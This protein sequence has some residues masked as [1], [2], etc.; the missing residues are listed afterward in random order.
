MVG[1]CDCSQELSLAGNG[2]DVEM[3]DTHTVEKKHRK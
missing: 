1:R 3:S 2:P